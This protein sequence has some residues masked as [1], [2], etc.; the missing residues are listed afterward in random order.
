M[1]PKPTDSRMSSHSAEITAGLR[2][3]HQ[4]RRCLA[5]VGDLPAFVLRH[6]VQSGRIDWWELLSDDRRLRL[7]DFE[8]RFGIESARDDYHLRN[9]NQIRATGR[10]QVASLFGYWDLYVPLV[11]EPQATLLFF[12][13]QF[14]RQLPTA[15]SIASAW[16]E[17]SGR[18]RSLEDETFRRWVRCC[19]AVPVLDDSMEKGLVELGALLGDLFAGES[20][21]LVQRKIERLRAHAF[22]PVIH[23]D[24]WVDSCLDGTGLTRPPW[25]LDRFLDARIAEE[26]QLSCKPSQLAI[27]VPQPN[28]SAGDDLLAD[29]VRRHHFQYYAR[30]LA[31][32]LPDTIAAPLGDQSVLLAL[33]LNPTVRGNARRAHFEE[34]CRRLQSQLEQRGFDSVAGLGGEVSPGQALGSCFRSAAAA[35]ESAIRQKRRLGRPITASQVDIGDAMARLEKLA[36]HLKHS[37][38]IHRFADVDTDITLYARDVLAIAGGSPQEMTFYFLGVLRDSLMSLEGLGFV[39]PEQ[40]H[41]LERQ[42]LAELAAITEPS[43]LLTEFDRAIRRVLL[44]RAE[45]KLAE[46]DERLRTTAEWARQNLGADGLLEQCARRTGLAASSFRRVFQQTYGVSFGRWL[47]QERL[48]LARETLGQ[49]ELTVTAIARSAGFHE[50]HAFIRCFKQ[51]FGQTPSA[52]RENAMAA[53]NGGSARPSTLRRGRSPVD[54]ALADATP[55]SRPS[56]P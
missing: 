48:D 20:P 19:L 21:R 42:F 14:A 35:L 6:D 7:Y 44:L 12:C 10:P 1:A 40:R 54:T 17:I 28:A 56:Q 38:D 32:A 8:F 2:G 45:G 23:D 50:I 27:L 11:M 29:W 26:R 43:R 22:L 53:A 33:A 36:R 39:S 18:Q 24:S 13:G 49:S 34:R 15:E 51:R 37:I 4:I 31:H 47:R 46:R 16:R 9:I 5:G 3:L 52:F 25:G 41:A 30:K 55:G